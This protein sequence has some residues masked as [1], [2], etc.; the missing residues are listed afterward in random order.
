M[1][2]SD[3]ERNGRIL[4]A[5]P[6]RDAFLPLLCTLFSASEKKTSLSDLFRAVATRFSRAGLLKNFPRQVSERIVERF[7]PR[8][9]DPAE[10]TA[11]RNELSRFFSKQLGFAEIRT[12]DYTD[13]VRI[14]FINGE[15]AHLR[16]S[17]NADELRIYAVADSR[18]RAEE[19]V[20][21]SLAEPSGILRSLETPAVR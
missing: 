10:Q 4:T 13:G 5:L 18:E 15:I 11:I 21:L 16:P 20:A 6:T 7:S 9:N 19:I 14:T 2:G 1:L 8:T 3:I 17:G 12:L